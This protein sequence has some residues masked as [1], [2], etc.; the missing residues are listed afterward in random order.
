MIYFYIAAA[1]ALL[2]EICGILEDIKY[3]KKY[4]TLGWF[5]WFYTAASFSWKAALF[6]F[7]YM[8]T[9]IDNILYGFI[10]Q[11]ASLLGVHS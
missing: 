10:M 3:N 9:Q 2:T 4:H 6:Y 1:L 11:L 7:L 5:R 8:M